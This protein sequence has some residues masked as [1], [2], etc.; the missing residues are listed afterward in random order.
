[1][2]V[3]FILNLHSYLYV[4]TLGNKG[5]IY[6]ENNNFNILNTHLIF[7]LYKYDIIS[8]DSNIIFGYSINSGV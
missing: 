8:Y 1:M 4:P 6:R 2:Y 7:V 3:R 5:E